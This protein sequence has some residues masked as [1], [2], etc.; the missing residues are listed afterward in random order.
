MATQFV[1]RAPPE[2][3]HLVHKVASARGEYVADL[4]RRAVKV[5]LARLS[6]LSDFEKKALGFEL[7]TSRNFK[8][9]Q[10]KPR[11]G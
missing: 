9:N 8:K 4:V 2:L 5:E 3:V 6:F 1:V 7:E 10:T 11:S